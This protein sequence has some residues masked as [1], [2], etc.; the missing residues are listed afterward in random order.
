LTE[1]ITPT[2]FPQSGRYP[3]VFDP[4]IDKTHLSHV[5]MDGG[6]SLN[7][8]YAET[9]VGGLSRVAMQPSGAP[10]YGVIPRLQAIPLEQ[11]NLKKRGRQRT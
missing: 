3:L 8:L 6:S 5:I 9:Y 4:I 11:V 10:F 7:L 1:R 2:T